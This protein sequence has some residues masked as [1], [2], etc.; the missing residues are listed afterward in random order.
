MSTMEL[1]PATTTPSERAAAG[2]AARRVVSREALGEWEPADDRPDPVEILVE[3]GRH[4]VPELLPV[5]Y[6]RMAVSP[7][8]FL[9]GAPAVMAHDLS[10]SP[11]TPLR[12]QLCG[13]AHLS[14]FGSYGTPERRLIFDLNDFDETLPG[15]FEWDVKRLCASL[16]VAARTSGQGEKAGRKAAVAAARTYRE[17]LCEL[18]PKDVLEV[19]YEHV[20]LSEAMQS[21]AGI[22]SPKKLAKQLEKTQHRT[23]SQVLTKLTEIIEGERRIRHQP[24]VLVPLDSPEWHD[25]AQDV[26]NRYA[27][28]MDDDHAL[29]LGRFRLVEIAMKV[30]GVG[31]VGTRCLIALMHGRDE[32]DVLFLQV[33]EAEHSVLAP[34][35]GDSTYEHQGQRVVAGQRLMQAASDL[36]LGWTDGPF[37][38]HYYI[39]QL[40]DMKGSVDIDGLSPEGLQRYGELCGRVL[41][42]AHARAADP[43]AIAGYLGKATRFDEAMGQFAIAYADQT[44]RDHARFLE[45]IDEGRITAEAG[46]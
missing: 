32:D 31:S 15:P 22:V 23:S 17:H 44:E 11:T 46:V 24:P 5:R 20:E 28:T 16:L 8:T 35:A 13:D 37:G 33:K 10:T 36:F 12:T 1:D 25:I 42:R 2:E 9:R 21:F 18:A 14:N 4:R 27:E 40:R 19:W 3:Q 34:Y 39:R 41:G 30:V 29:L 6:G 43:S 26:L 45:A 38:N 7:F